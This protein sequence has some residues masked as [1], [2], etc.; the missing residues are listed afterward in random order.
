LT[1][2]GVGHNKVE[3]VSSAYSLETETPA[4]KKKKKKKK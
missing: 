4:P 2:K 1:G 3:A